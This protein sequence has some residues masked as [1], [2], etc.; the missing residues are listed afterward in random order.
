MEHTQNLQY[1]LYPLSLSGKPKVISKRFLAYFYFKGF[2]ND[3]KAQQFWRLSPLILPMYQILEHIAEKAL[4][5]APHIISILT[6][7][8]V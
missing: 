7:D 8:Q 2:R 1:A 5:I 6:T 4:N 3:R